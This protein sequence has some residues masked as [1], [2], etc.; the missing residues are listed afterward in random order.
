M[1]KIFQT[2]VCTI[3]A[4]GISAAVMAQSDEKNEK[5]KEK[6]LKDAKVKNK[7]KDYDEI[8]IKKVGDKDAKVVIEIKGDDVLV[9]GK[10]LSDYDDD[11]IIVR[12]N[13][14][15]VWNGNA[16]AL[17][18]VGSPFRQ[19][20]MGLSNSAFLGVTTERDDKGARIVDITEKSAAEKSGLKE[21]DVIVKIDDTKVEDHDDLSKAI[22]K[23]KPEDK[24]TVTY[25]RDGKQA[26]ATA[27]L[28]KHSF[29]YNGTYTMPSIA[30]PEFHF[31]M[32]QNGIE[33]LTAYGFF[34]PRIGIRAQDTEDGKGVKVIDVADESLA[35][36]GGIKEGDIITEFDGKTVNDAD[37]LADAARDAKEKTTINVKFTRDGKSQSVD[38]KIPKKLKT[39][40]L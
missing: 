31:D 27:T 4:F 26:T 13:N 16:R 14:V 21:G 17:T 24:V 38:L 3:L 15:S 7:F 1:K 29:S 37:A 33:P 39:A 5:L 40:N 22:G 23:H 28:G 6:E 30:A 10:P 36:K 25:L 2:A 9:N 12:K 34:R 32:G 20:I 35:D 8:I 19:N 11:N 18:T